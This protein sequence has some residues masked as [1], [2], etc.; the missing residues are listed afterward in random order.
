MSN[1]KKQ[2][3]MRKI[4]LPLAAALII[5]IAGV[6]VYM[7][8]FHVPESIIR[9]AVR[10][11][12]VTD[13]NYILCKRT[14]TTGFDWALIRDEYGNA[15]NEVCNIVGANPFYELNLKADFVFSENIYVFYIEEKNTYYSEEMKM[16]ML[17]Y[18]VTGWDILYPVKHGGL[19]LF[20]PR[21]YITDKDLT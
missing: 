10:E 18:V 1:I 15:S 4:A 7:K 5:M 13:G 19:N 11:K 21:K 6:S 8:I 12:E 3:A 20:S 16:D 9:T 17:E 2:I 14:V